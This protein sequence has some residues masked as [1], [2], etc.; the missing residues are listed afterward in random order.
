MRAAYVTT[1]L[2]ALLPAWGYGRGLWDACPAQPEPEYPH[3]TAGRIEIRSHLARYLEGRSLFSGQAEAI[4]GERYLR[5][6]ELEYDTVDRTLEARGNVLFREPRLV[7]EA[8]RGTLNL[9]S[10]ALWVENPRYRIPARHAR[11][12][13]AEARRR[14]PGVLELERASFTTCPLGGEDWRLVAAKVRLDRDEGVGTARH[15]R[16]EVRGVPILYSPYARFPLDNRRRT[17]FLTPSIGSSSRSGFQFVLPLYLNLAPNYDATLTGRYL[18]ERGV[19]GLGELRYLLP[20]HSGKLAMALLDDRKT[21]A[22]RSRFDF[23]HHSRLTQRWTAELRYQSVSD[24]DY[25]TDLGDTLGQTSRTHL[26]RYANLQYAAETWRLLA[27]AQDFQTVDPAIAPVNFPYARLPRFDLLGRDPTGPWGLDLTWHGEW[28]HF[29]HP[30]KTSGMRLDGGLELRRPIERPAWRL[31]PTVG[32]RFTGYALDDVPVDDHPMRALPYAALEAGLAFERPWKEGELVQ[33]LTPRL[34][35]L[36]VPYEDQ[37]DIPLFDTNLFDFGYAQLFRNN[38]FTGADRVGD[39]NQLTLALE[40]TLL[41]P[42]TGRVLAGAGI[43]QIVYFADRRVTLPGRPVQTGRFSNLVGEAHMAFGPGWRLQGELQWD[44]QAAR[45][46]RAAVAMR[47]RDPGERLFN[48]GYRE[49]FGILQLF[50]VSMALPITRHLRGVARWSY[51]LRND[52]TQDALAAL[53]YDTCCWALRLAFRRVFRGDLGDDPYNDSFQF[54]LVLKGLT[55]IGNDV[56]ELL[57]R[58]V[59]GYLPRGW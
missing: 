31:A 3:G 4:D 28:V 48:L 27:Q 23:R 26:A 7:V 51:D 30:R 50:D 21:G 45:L 44:P 6:D 41:E 15:A 38:R 32:F 37:T 46:D 42:A 54:Q 17:G 55:S 43:G 19:Q 52:N 12:E 10:G 1:L 2:L 18:A 14:E 29:E 11:G 56:D 34:R 53:E 39:A 49:R 57:A 16:F 33:T 20:G 40:S 47:Y 58:D 59:V 35:Y 36:Y 25:F 13:A 5:A 22:L 24:Q 9:G 8:A